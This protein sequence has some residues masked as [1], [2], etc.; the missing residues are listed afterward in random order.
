MGICVSSRRALTAFGALFGLRRPVAWARNWSPARRAVG[1]GFVLV[2]VSG[3]SAYAAGTSGGSVV[4]PGVREALEH[5]LQAPGPAVVSQ[6]GAGGAGDT[7]AP[8]GE[9]VSS[10]STAYSDTWRTP[11]HPSVT[12]IFSVPV[13]YKG[14]DGAWHTIDNALVASPLGGY[15]NTANSFSL[16]LPESISSGVSLTYKGSTV[17]F[18]LLGAAASLPSV[19]G[20]S[21]SYAE[22]LP[23]TDLSYVSE[24]TGVQELVTL[25]DSSAPSQLRYSLSLPAGMSPRAETDGSIALLDGEGHVVFTIPAATAYRPSAGPGSGRTLSSSVVAS[26]SGWTITVNTG[27]A[28]L[29]EELAAGA[30]YIDPT[31]S[32]AASAGC[33][34]AAEAPTTSACSSSEQRVGYDSTH[35]ENHAL[36]NFDLSSLPVGYVVLDAKLGLYVQAHSTS[37]AKAV[38]VYRVTKPW[39]TSATWNT[40]DGTHAWSAP[41]GDYS[42]PSSNSDAS[43]NPSVGA[44]T[45][46]Y[47]WYPTKMVQEWVNTSNAP[48]LEKGKPEGYANEGLIVKDQTDS[49][50][51]NL[52]TVDSPSASSNQPYLEVVYRAHGEGSEPQ[53]TMLSANLTD[54]S[55]MSVNVA[56]GDLM[57]QSSQLQ[58]PGIAGFGFASTR[59]WNNLNG[60]KQSY[61]HWLDSNDI[62]IGEFGDGSV[63]YQSPSGAWFVFQ[64]QANGSFIT[65]PGI[66]AN[67]CA[68]GS[69][70]PCPTSLPSGVAHE[71]IFDESQDHINFNASG[72][73]VKQQDHYENTVSQEYPSEEHKLFTDPQGH[74]I[75]QIGGEESNIKEIKDLT[76]S[77]NIKFTYKDFGEGE[78]ELE[79]ATDANGK[80]T[81]YEYSGYSITK[82]TDPNGNVTK[83][84]YDSKRRVTEL[85]R[86]TNSGHTEGPTTKFKYYEPGEA[87]SPCTS[88]QRGTVA[89]DP[90]WKKAGE[91]AHEALYCSNVLGEVEKTLDAKHH[92]SS[93]T[94]NPFG[95]QTSTTAF[96]PGTGEKGPVTSLNYLPG[97]ADLE[98]AIQ[99]TTK[100][101][102]TCPSSRPDKSALVTSFSYTQKN[103]PYSPSGAENPENNSIF[104]CYNNGGQEKPKEGEPTC[105]TG[106]TGPA[107]SPQNKNDQL[108]EQ[109]EL[110]FEYNTKG[111]IKSSTDADG[112]TTTYEYDE[113]ENLKKI[114]PPTGSGI[115]PTTITVDAN[116][117]PHVIT[118]G[119]GHV[120]TITYDNDNRITKIEYTGTGTAKTVKYEY[121]A[122]G[123]LS[124]REDSTGTT[125]YT[126]D[127]LN[128]VTKEELPGSLTNSYEYDLASNKTSFT[129]GGGKTKYEYN[130]LNEL[131]AMTEPGAA[132]A[133]TFTYDNAHQMTGITYPSKA[134]ETYKLEEATGRP[135]TITAEGVSGTSV[136]KLTYTYKE[137]ENP[138]SL[139]KTLTEST[140]G[141][142]TSYAY[143]PLERLKEAVT[144]TAHQQRYA[145]TLDGAGNR[146]TQTVNLSGETGG[147]PSYYAYNTGNELE[148]R[149]TVATPCSGSSTTELSHYSYDHAGEQTAITPK[150]D[151]SGAS[152]EY[153]AASELTGLTPSGGSALALSYGGTGQDDLLSI[154]STTTIQN[155]LLGVTREVTSAG[156]SYYAR[157][158]NGLLIDERTPSGN[159]NPLYDAQGDIIAL[160][161]TSGKVERTFHYGPYGEN[162]K[163][164]GTQTIPYPF[165]YKAGYR[166][167]AGNTGLE[168]VPNSLVHYGQRY[169]DPT[170]GRWTQQDGITRANNP[171]LANRYPYV[172]DDSVNLADPNGTTPISEDG[173]QYH[174]PHEF[175]CNGTSGYKQDECY[176]IR[177][178][179]MNGESMGELGAEYAPPSIPDLHM[180]GG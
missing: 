168:N 60:E 42:N 147:T 104:T 7:A 18:S 100:P 174:Y 56:S 97:G 117:R 131:T 169:Y 51:A 25:K 138:T 72:D 62:A 98:C 38:G 87:P 29:R 64:K 154:G 153:N 96:A 74:K 158:P 88:T 91:E 67:M 155:S 177:Q 5:E 167:A 164:E 166:M 12:R 3:S 141:A 105:P 89:E 9:L 160:A 58:T 17:S 162:I 71:L 172:G 54:S 11:H 150:H 120:E 55:T 79:S 122:D 35:Q 140:S 13:N 28:W 82:V 90:L 165:G 159:Y 36:L 59:T 80:T 161:N 93:T 132:T 43:V 1:L 137:G 146:L 139:T 26:G 68:A 92:E 109:H 112:H 111:T 52:L 15:E 136:P 163:S 65:P 76:G 75:E 69:P 70:S 40:Y 22:V 48:E 39:T 175:F 119:A 116:S 6:G 23:S 171:G 176:V 170:S 179:E 125:N 66:K 121:D 84:V 115:E 37:A 46:W 85:I 30:V 152:F 106:T 49:Q 102:T 129:D 101:E 180:L 21:A 20:D 135:E 113:H 32:L 50:T 44:S 133:T 81:Y 41:G 149:Q 130:G 157:T 61:G 45:G 94:F 78:P 33:S 110:K 57:L 134:K 145:F 99:G 107:G 144:K 128:R 95:D 19:S 27:D 123:N 148:C 47:Y 4:S 142:V 8:S 114:K 178:A 143:D 73:W 86:T 124:K 63:N 118:D 24:A 108:S 53:Y 14:S 34:L 173:Y 83:F 16:R 31:V 151:T 10:L 126:V 2:L 156:T 77:R 103:M 127:A